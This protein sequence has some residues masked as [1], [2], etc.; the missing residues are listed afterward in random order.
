MV[1]VII[2]LTEVSNV[3]ILIS[4]LNIHFTVPSA[5]TN[6]VYHYVYKN[7]KLHI[8]FLTVK[9]WYISNLI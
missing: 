3:T 7:V 5:V 8:T 4:V 9:A 2:P 1:S 6:Y